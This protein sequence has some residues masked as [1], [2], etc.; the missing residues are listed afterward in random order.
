MTPNTKQQPQMNTHS[1]NISPSLTR[2]PENNQVPFSIILKKL[3]FINCPNPELALDSRDQRGPLEDGTGEGFES[4]GDLSDIGD[5]RMETG[6]ADILLS[7]ALLG[8]NKACGAVDADD[9]VSGDFGIES[10]AVTGLFDTEEALDPSDDLVGG[11]VGGFIEVEDAVLEVLSEG[12]FERGVTGG[13][14][15][16]VSGADVET[17]VVFEEDGPL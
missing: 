15:G 14:G 8:F 13:D 7:S 2:N 3:T 12:A 17:V 9:E 6:N 5:S 10:A 11:R 16:V 1:P 4:T